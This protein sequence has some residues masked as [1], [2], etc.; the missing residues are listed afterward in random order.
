MSKFTPTP[1]SLVHPPQD[2]RMFQLLVESVRDYAIFM[3]DPA[4]RVVSWNEGAEAIKGYSRDEI[5]GRHFSCFYPKEQVDRGWPDYELTRA[6][7]DGRFED[8]SWRVR[9]DGS[10]FWANVIIT[11]LRDE[12]GELLGF[13]KVTRDLSERRQQEE[14]LRQSEERFRTLVEHVS[15]YAIFMLTPEGFVTTWNTGARQI[16]GYEPDEIMGSHLSRFYPPEAIRAAWP[17]HELRVARMEGRFEDEGWRIRKD[18]SRFWANVV[19]TALRDPN[20]EL[21]GFSKITRDLTERRRQE[22]ALAQ[23]E[24]RFRLLVEGVDDYAIFMADRNGFVSSWNSGAERISG[25]TAKEILGKHFSHFY[26][27]EDVAAHKPWK[28]LSEAR[29]SG[30]V[31]DEGWRARKD[32][33]LFWASSVMT[34]LH[35]ADGR[36]YGFANVMQDLTKRRH[37]EALADRTQRMHEFIAMLAH[38]L[39]NP[40]APIRNAVELMGRKGIGDPLL[41]SMRQTIDRQSTL[42][43]R[44]VDEFLDANRIARGKFMVDLEPVDLST[45]VSRAVETTRPLIDAQGQ[46]LEIDAPESALWLKGDSLR[47]TQVIVNLLNNAAK[48][49]PHGGRISLGVERRGTDIEIRVRDNGRGIDAD[50]LESIFD[51]FTQISPESVRGQGGLGVGLALVRRVVELHGGIVQARSDGIGRGAEF[52]VRLPLG[53][54]TVQGVPSPEQDSDEKTKR[55]RVL[56]VDDNKDAADSLH[57]LLEAIGQDVVTVYDGLAA[58]DAI[59]KFKPDVVMLDIGM[60]VLSGYDVA[61]KIR[62]AMPDDRRPILA[63]V[64]GWGQETDRTRTREAGFAYHFVKPVEIGSLRKL[65]GDVSGLR[66]GNASHHP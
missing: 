12:N 48:F 22:Q 62:E 55:L 9:K 58:L 13:S 38:E 60:P 3:L 32:G 7:A 27:S 23:S 24:E 49:T 42:L 18:G 6:A 61:S 54:D 40:L 44:I 53:V 8:E 14:A 20:G 50:H 31:S 37:A 36:P 4:G 51:L 21:V 17:E 56:V 43:T 1:L 35:D 66:A 52:I 63:A 11:A 33:T 65:I 57:L 5:L 19:I 47:L 64:T 41:E 45:V 16:T 15:D 46:H 39:R 59:E 26:T 34:A 25:Y 30:R 28:Q 29:D 2:G 10:R